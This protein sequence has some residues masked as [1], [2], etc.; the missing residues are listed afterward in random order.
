M[1]WQSL[2]SVKCSEFPV[3]VLQW[4]HRPRSLVRAIFRCERDVSKES[5][6]KHISRAV[7][8]RH[9]TLENHEQVWNVLDYRERCGRSA[10]MWRVFLVRNLTIAKVSRDLTSRIYF[11]D[12]EN[13]ILNKALCSESVARVKFTHILREFFLFYLILLIV[14]KKA[15]LVSDL[16]ASILT[17]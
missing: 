15:I 2:S 4:P 3:Y 1:F 8:R 7:A 5:F 10:D 17:Q 16:R 9:S 14:H 6:D 12:Q 13:V 11:H